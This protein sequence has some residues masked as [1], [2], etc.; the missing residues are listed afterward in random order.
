MKIP[1]WLSMYKRLVMLCIL[2]FL[3]TSCSSSMSEEPLNMGRVN[4]DSIQKNFRTDILSKYERVEE[5]ELIIPSSEKPKIDTSQPQEESQELQLWRD[6]ITEPWKEIPD[7]KFF[8]V[9]DILY[10]GI[11]DYESQFA[12]YFQQVRNQF[13]RD[14][15][16]VNSMVDIQLQQDNRSTIQFPT[17]DFSSP[18]FVCSSR[19]T[20]KLSNGDITSPMMSTLTWNYYLDGAAI[21][22]TISFTLR[23]S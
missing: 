3:L 18:L 17:K 6:S 12:K 21:K 4:V 7:G 23:N 15:V 20:L 13:E 14:G 11:M 5:V 22:Y 2:T 19:M 8:M 16:T 9:C 1:I 10:K